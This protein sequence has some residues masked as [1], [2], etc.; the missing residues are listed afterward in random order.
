MLK[1]QFVLLALLCISCKGSVYDT[2]E[3]SFP[4]DSQPHEQGWKYSGTVKIS[5]SGPSYEVND[6]DVRVYVRDR[7]GKQVLLDKFKIHAGSIRTDVQWERERQ[8][9]IEL[10]D[11]GSPPA[12]EEYNGQQLRRAPLL[13]RS[14]S[15]DPIE[16]LTSL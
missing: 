15:Y 2:K 12:L 6:K 13:V 4:P 9:H 14:L 8:L 7:F 1:V 3:F 10:Y 16:A 5:M 11:E